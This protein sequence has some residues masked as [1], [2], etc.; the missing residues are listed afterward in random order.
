MLGSVLCSP[1]CFSVYRAAA[2]RD[3]LPIYSSKV[4]NST[5]FL[6]KDMGKLRS[7]G[8]RGSMS[9]CGENPLPRTVWPGACFSKALL[10]FKMAATQKTSPFCLVNWQLNQSVKLS[11]FR[12]LMYT[13]SSF[14]GPVRTG[15]FEKLANRV[16]TPQGMPYMSTGR[17][18]FWFSPWLLRFSP[19]LKNAANQNFSSMHLWYGGRKAVLPTY[20][21]QSSVFG[22]VSANY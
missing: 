21:P 16:Y 3:V 8:G 17:V 15:T 12:S 6:T 18:Y 5:D 11:K 19:L 2:L 14:Q 13:H 9:L 4:N 7:V 1:G 20:L 22:N 10:W